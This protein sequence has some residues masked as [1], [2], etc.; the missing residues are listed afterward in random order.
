MADEATMIEDERP[1]TAFKPSKRETTV[2]NTYRQRQ[3]QRRAAMAR[4]YGASHPSS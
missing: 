2:V 1:T 4:T 3:Q